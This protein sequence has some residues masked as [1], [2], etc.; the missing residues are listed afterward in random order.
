M[1]LSKKEAH[2]AIKLMGY[3]V[4]D[5]GQAVFRSTFQDYNY[6]AGSVRNESWFNN[7]IEPHH[8]NSMASLTLQEPIYYGELSYSFWVVAALLANYT[9]YHDVIVP[10]AYDGAS[11]QFQQLYLSKSTQASNDIRRSILTT[12]PAASTFVN[13]EKMVYRGFLFGTELHLETN[14]T[15]KIVID[16]S[17]HFHGYVFRIK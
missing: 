8:Y 13:L 2:D 4:F 6:L 9:I 1:M 11:A 16:E 10:R 15:G 14:A 12:V 17:I 5:D 7:L 3:P